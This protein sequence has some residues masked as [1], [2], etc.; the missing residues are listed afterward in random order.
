MNQEQQGARIRPVILA[1]GSGTRLWPMST[2]ATPKHLLPLIGDTSLFEQTLDRF[3]DRARFGAPIVVAN[4]AQETALTALLAPVAGAQLVLEPMKRDSAP[5]IALAALVAEPDDMLLMS[6]SDHHIADVPAFHAAIETGRAAAEG[7]DIVTFGIEP[8]HPATGFGYI[9]AS[10]GDGVRRVER[11]IEKPDVERAQALLDAG[12]HYWNAGIFLARA[13]TWLAAMER[14]V[15]DM[16]A[17]ARAALAAADR[18][19]G[20]IRP[21]TAEFARSPAQ[22]IDYAVME[23]ESAISVVPVSMGWSDIGSWESLF[24]AALR[25]GDDNSVG[26]GNLALGSAGNLIRSSGPRVAA[27]GVE[28]LVIIATKDAVLVVPRDQSQRVREAAAWFEEETKA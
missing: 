16:L 13:S 22:S 15:P 20:I 14:H 21:G 17:A 7:G 1:G 11:F 27:I 4:L 8:D 26:A 23:K 10:D 3:A 19:G 5:A 6:P 2:A 24:D 18:D 12:G 9:A 28:G 25:D